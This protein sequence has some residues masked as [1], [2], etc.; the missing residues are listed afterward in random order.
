MIG[1]SKEVVAYRSGQ[2]PLRA[3]LKICKGS[4][5]DLERII[6]IK[7]ELANFRKRDPIDRDLTDD[8]LEK[9]RKKDNEDDLSKYN[10]QRGYERG[11]QPP[12]DEH[13]HYSD[14]RYNITLKYG[15][16]PIAITSFEP[17][18]QALFII[19]IQGG[20]SNLKGTINKKILLSPLKWT[21]MLVEIVE[22]I[23]KI[24][25]IPEVWILSSERNKWIS[26]KTFPYLKPMGDLKMIYDVTARRRGYRYDEKRKVYVKS[27]SN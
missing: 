17:Q 19:Q 22:G 5:F 16:M 8:V 10:L 12:H 1:E 3:A 14:S 13:S 15:E 25:Q 6:G 23:A 27:I 9:N 18:R 7:K 24:H 21:H 20:A 26:Q 11:S 2:G 4:P